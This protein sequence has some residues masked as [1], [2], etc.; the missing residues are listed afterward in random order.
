MDTFP[1]VQSEY[2]T[3]FGRQAFQP[4]CRIVENQ[5]IIGLFTYMSGFLYRDFVSGNRWFEIL[6]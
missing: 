2:L 5:K 1:V 6:N 4:V 3:D